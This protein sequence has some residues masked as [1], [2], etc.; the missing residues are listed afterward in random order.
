[1]VKKLLVGFLVTAFTSSAL[2]QEQIRKKPSGTR[3]QLATIVFA[4]LGGAVLGLSTLSFYGRPQEELANIAIGF[5]LGVIGG[6]IYVTFKSATTREYFDEN[7]EKQKGVYSAPPPPSEL[8]IGPLV[9]TRRNTDTVL[10][11]QM[12]YHF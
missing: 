6:T 8:R 4:G 2:A 1:M 12:A 9:E 7:G 10:G 11:A 5:A 3:R